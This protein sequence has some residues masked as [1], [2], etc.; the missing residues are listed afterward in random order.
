MEKLK[1]RR[2]GYALGAE[3]TG[4]DAARPLDPPT[5]EA[6][7]GA[8]LD[9]VVLCLPGQNLEG[10]SMRTFCA[11]FGE[12]DDG[13]GFNSHPD[14]THVM[15]IANRPAMVDGKPTVGYVR[16]EL[17]HSDFS[18]D[19]CPTPISF[20]CAKELPE[21]GGDTMFANMYM[22]YETL[23]PTMRE[24]LDGLSAVHDIAMGPGYAAR[25]PEQRVKMS[26]DNPPVVHPVVRVHPETGRKALYGVGDRVRSFVGMTDEESRPLIDFLNAHA[27]RYELS[28]RHRWTV[29]DLVIWDNRCAMHMALPDYEYKTELRRMLRCSTLGPKTGHLYSEADAQPASLASAA[30]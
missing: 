29:G 11:Q 15:I 1:V 26:R 18:F 28:Y 4:L 14:Y 24:L 27:T 9:H 23:S 6:L 21:V 30:V 10:Q 8:L 20:L 7:R 5:L 17:W 12:L 19:V 25:S 16:G 2:L 13:G 22:A 3:V